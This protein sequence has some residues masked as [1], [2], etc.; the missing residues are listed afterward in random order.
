[1][2][3]FLRSLRAFDQHDLTPIPRPPMVTHH[4]LTP[5]AACSASQAARGCLDGG[6]EASEPGAPLASLVK[7]PSP[8]V[9]H[10]PHTCVG[11]GYLAHSPISETL[12]SF[13]PI[14]VASQGHGCSFRPLTRPLS[15]N[16]REA[17]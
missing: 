11:G 8:A 10:V 6:G 16:L 2:Q 13:Q 14:G 9:C 4:A 5:S 1:M 7:S 17:A 15:L 12:S 3:L